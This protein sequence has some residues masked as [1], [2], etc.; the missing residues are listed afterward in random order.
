VA[1][2]DEV[3][4]GR[5]AGVGGDWAVARGAAPARLTRALS[6]DARAATHAA[7]LYAVFTETLL[8]TI[9]TLL[10]LVTAMCKLKRSLF[11]NQKIDCILVFHRP[12]SFVF[13]TDF[14]LTLMPL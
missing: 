3:A 7:A 8:S 6:A 14:W 12:E 13:R 2:A 5:A 10:Q 1:G 4:G 9:S 11:C